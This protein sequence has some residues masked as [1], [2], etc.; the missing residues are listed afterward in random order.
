MTR[1]HGFTPGER[2]RPQRD[3]PSLRP[4]QAT[5]RFRGRTYRIGIVD[6][7]DVRVAGGLLTDAVDL[8]HLAE[9]ILVL[10]AAADELR[11]GRSGEVGDCEGG[12]R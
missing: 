4:G 7:G 8:D 3:A 9:L 12:G 1:P 5:V 2:P 6:D 10:D 11:E